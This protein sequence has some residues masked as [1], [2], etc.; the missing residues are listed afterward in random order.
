MLKKTFLKT[1]IEASL[2]EL[3]TELRL[4]YNERLIS[5]V[6]YGSYARDAACEGSDIDVVVV[7][8]G[9]VS[10]GREIDRMLDA[11]NDLNL[12]YNT[13]ISVYPLSEKSFLTLRSPLLLNLRREGVHL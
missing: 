11:V 5:V 2:A 6:L 9:R 3:K 4:L 10:P 7:L 8:K 1:D 13:L 12:K